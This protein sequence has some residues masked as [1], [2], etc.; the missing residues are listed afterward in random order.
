VKIN[1]FLL[2]L[3]ISIFSSLYAQ[4]EILTLD[5]AIEKAFSQNPQLMAGNYTVEAAKERDKRAYAGYMPSLS[6]TTSYAR[7]TGNQ[8]SKP[9][10]PG[11][12]A[13]SP[14]NDSYNYYSLGITLNQTIYDFGRT[15]GAT[16]I[17]EAQL[18]SDIQD[19]NVLKLSVWELVSLR[20]SL[21]LTNQE[22]LAVAKRNVETS[23]KHLEHSKAL[24]ENG[25]R[26]KLDMLRLEVELRNAEAVYISASSALKISKN[27]LLAALG[28]KDFFDFTAERFDVSC[29]K[30]SSSGIASYSTDALVTRPEIAAIKEKIKLSAMT[31]KTIKSDYFPIL[32]F[33]ATFSDAGTE[34]SDLTWNWG[35]G[36]GISWPLFTGLST[37]R[38]MKE[39]ENKLSALKFSQTTVEIQIKSEIVQAFEN[40]EAADARIAVYE[41]AVISS[42]EANNAAESRYEAGSGTVIELLD[43]STALANSEANLVKA[44]LERSLAYVRWQKALGKIPEK[45]S[46]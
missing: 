34:I 25:L 22:L 13:N 10:V 18:K 6:F 30:P 31:L 16:K 29:S 38:S 21:V 12:S 44:E 41:A 42:K 8:T 43:A 15:T 33:T 40:I 28:I 36:V 17:S 24:F 37:Y 45:Y 4:S 35:V 32:G 14:D 20:Y 39:A 7:Q 26:P 2:I 5:E 27:E 1:I 9:G 46:K 11:T 19:I 23:K 3:L